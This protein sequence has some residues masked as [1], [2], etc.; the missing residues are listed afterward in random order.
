MKAAGSYG[1]Y[2]RSRLVPAAGGIVVQV[3]EGNTGEHYE[4]IGSKEKLQAN[5]ATDGRI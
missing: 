2:Q 1:S 5:Q 4:Q 3:F